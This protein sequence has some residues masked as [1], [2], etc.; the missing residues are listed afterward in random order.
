MYRHVMQHL[1]NTLL[2]V[3]FV[4][5]LFVSSFFPFFF[6]LPQWPML[7]NAFGRCG[8]PMISSQTKANPF[9][10]YLFYA[11]KGV[12]FAVVNKN[13]HIASVTLFSV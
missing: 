7:R 12:I 13:E 8:R 6:F 10:P 5:F 3:F 4:F 1:H 9:P 11:Y 2:F